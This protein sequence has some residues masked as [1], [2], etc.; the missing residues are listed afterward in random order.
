MATENRLGQIDSSSFKSSTPIGE[1]AQSPDEDT[2]RPSPLVAFC[3]QHAMRATQY[4]PF[5]IIQPASEFFQSKIVI[6]H[7]PSIL[8]RIDVD[9]SQAYVPIG[10]Y[11]R[12][13]G[14]DERA[15][16]QADGLLIHPEVSLCVLVD[17]IQHV[18]TRVDWFPVLQKLRMWLGI[19]TTRCL[20]A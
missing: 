4:L 2:G 9:H 5:P 12:T 3:Y 15:I 8:G 7:Q 18:L 16:N 13:S 6:P 1:L 20:F 11:V 10:I 19:Q 14:C 17:A